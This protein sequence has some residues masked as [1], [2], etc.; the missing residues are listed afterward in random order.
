[1]AE[2]LLELFSE[3]IPARMQL[4]AAEDL[5]R[6]VV[7]KLAA[8]QLS[9]ESA[10]AFVT[11]RRLTLVVAG[12]P[13]AQPDVA[14]EKRGPRVGAP[15]AAVQGFLKSAGIAS[16]AECEERDTG[17]GVFYFAIIRRAGRATAQL[18]PEL[19][20][21]AIVELPWAK[22][23]RFPAAPFRWVRPLSSVVSLLN[24]RVLPLDV[25][26]VP[27]GAETRGHRFLAPAPITVT[28]FADYAEKLRAAYVILDPTVRRQKIA[29][30]L[31]LMAKGEGLR[32]ADD[33]GLLDEVTGLVEFPV[34]LVGRIE[35]EFMALPPEVLTTSM[36]ANQKYFALLD[37]QGA[38]APK[39]L[40]VA[41]NLTEDGGTVIVAGNERVLRARL[42]DA[43]FFWDQDR[44]ATLESRVEK[45]AERIYLANLGN[46]LDKI[47]R[48]ERLTKKLAPYVP[49]ASAELSCRAAH[50][51][52][53]DLSTGMVGEFPEL[54]GVMGR[55]Y[56]LH[57][58]EPI[59]IA[60][61]VAEHYSPL[62]PNDRCPTAPTSVV[63]ALADK[64]DTLVGFFAIDEKPTGSRDPYGLRRA[65]L[66]V[67]RLILENKLRLPLQ[68]IFWEAVS[69]L[70]SESWFSIASKRPYAPADSS[71]S[72]AQPAV[73]GELLAFFADRLKV[74]LREQGVRHDLIAAVFAPRPPHPPVAAATG[75]SLSRMRERGKEDAAASPSPLAGEGGAPRSG[76]GEGAVASD[77]VEDDLVRLLARVAALDEFLRT[78][79]GANLLT[80]YRRA[81]N[82]VRIEEKKDG[83]SHNE[84]PDL[85][86]LR[87]PEEAALAER[88]AE[89]E[90]LSGAA[91]AREEFGVAMAALATL[92]RPVDAF[93]DRVTV[94]DAD[95]ALRANRLRLLARIKATL[96]RVA[97]FAQIEG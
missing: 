76:E 6:L 68:R 35:P 26:A 1:M 12:L 29:D 48:V 79:D 80:A 46:L 27:V 44:K 18:L 89:V 61:A 93:F 19:L 97:D 30:D 60:D 38:L 77:A 43:K 10:Q 8:A 14:E 37:A 47:F 42:A 24:G 9:H 90:R 40:V 21:A 22:S 82:I 2:L 7:D 13:L 78:E 39:F 55:Y 96:D 33:P 41:N 53:A 11:A 52:K 16:L 88:L 57:D 32:L 25:G 67:I 64:I 92:R 71:W 15:E 94:N 73:I 54:Q 63:V 5:R 45:L 31:A 72:K 70:T 65:A 3:E 34:V 50:L 4:R 49:G 83:H 66:G 17:K 36:R 95:G 58:G 74:H 75:P 69:I 85:T 87:Q 91:L 86:L 81:A 51:S 56:A 59:E 20:R 23:M 28:N 84:A 62:G